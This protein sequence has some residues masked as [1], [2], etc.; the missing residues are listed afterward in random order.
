MRGVFNQFLRIPDVMVMWMMS[1]PNCC[2]VHSFGIASVFP[3]LTNIPILDALSERN[4][5]MVS[6]AQKRAYAKYNSKCDFINVRLPRGYRNLLRQQAD[7][8]GISVNA[9]LRRAIENDILHAHT[10]S[11]G[12]SEAVAPKI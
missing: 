1:H 10:S 3:K 7:N 2:E 4:I 11:D 5:I 12:S 8:E 6:D 9:M